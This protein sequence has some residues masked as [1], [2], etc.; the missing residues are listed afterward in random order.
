MSPF[1]VIFFI[2]RF[3]IVLIVQNF[4]NRKYYCFDYYFDYYFDFYFDYYFDYYCDYYC[5]CDDYFKH[6]FDYFYYF[7]YY[8]DYYRK[9]SFIHGVKATMEDWDMEQLMTVLYQL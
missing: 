7:D 8:F 9:E 4:E 2:F 5:D 3:Y 1:T 6:Y